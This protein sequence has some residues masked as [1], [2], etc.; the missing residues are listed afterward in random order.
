[1]LEAV[2]PVVFGVVGALIVAHQPRNTIGWLLM[3]IALGWTIGGL[4]ASYLPLPTAATPDPT[5]AL[6][7]SAWFSEWNWWL[8]IDPLLLILLLFPTGKPP[9]PRRRWV[10]V[11]VAALFS[12]FLVAVTFSETIQVDTNVRLRNPLGIIPDSVSSPFLNGPWLIMLLTTVTFCVAAV[13]VRYRRA[14]AQERAQIK[15]FLYACAV[16]F[17]VYVIA[18]F[19]DDTTVL[20]AW[21]SIVFNLVILTMPSSIGIA[22]LRYRLYDIDVIIRRTLVYSMLTFTLGL[23]YVGCILLS[24]AFVAPLV[25]ASELAII[26]STLVIAALFNPL[27]R[28]IQNIIDR[29]FYRRKYDAAKVLAAFGVTARDE[30]DLEILTTELVRVADETMQPEFVGLWLRTP[31]AGSTTEAA[32]P[33]ARSP[34]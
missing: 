26:A 25:G 30:T 16:F 11:A 31:Q 18:A 32:R 15:W 17:I 9:S 21:F 2:I 33:G 23:M 10:I 24:R 6:L 27:R 12:I 13:F 4:I 3:V 5:P 28:R 1:V 22:I 7:L 14:A 8:L 19:Q 34:N 29:R 20:G